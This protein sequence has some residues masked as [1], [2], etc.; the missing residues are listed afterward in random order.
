MELY[1]QFELEDCPVCGGGGLLE[2][3]NHS[4][5]AVSCFECGAHTVTIDFKS[6]E[7]KADSAK[8]AADLWNTGK[9]I[10]SE[11]GE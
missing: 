8:K 9:V 6:E 1:E 11:P 4:G 10:A 3:E 5:F 2:E 7:G